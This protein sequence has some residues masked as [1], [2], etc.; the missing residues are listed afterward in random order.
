MIVDSVITWLFEGN[1]NREPPIFEPIIKCNTD[2][3][4]MN[5]DLYKR[6][7]LENFEFFNKTQVAVIDSKILFQYNN[8]ENSSKIHVSICNENG[9]WIG[10]DLKCKLEANI[11]KQIFIN[12]SFTI[13]IILISTL[14]LVLIIFAII[15]TIFIIH[16][17]KFSKK[18]IDSCYTKNLCINELYEETNQNRN[19]SEII[20]SNLDENI[21]SEINYD[22]LNAETNQTDEQTGV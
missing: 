6:I 22:E 5:S 20:D 8:E 7:K 18:R 12:H 13:I 15:G 21:Y 4:D 10:N 2:E 3:I 11:E 14:V 16:R 19:Y 17:K 1:S 9:L